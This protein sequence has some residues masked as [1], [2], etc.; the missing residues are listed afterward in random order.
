MQ[1]GTKTSDAATITDHCI[2]LKPLSDTKHHLNANTSS[3]FTYA[4]VEDDRRHKEEAQD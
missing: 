4:I 1:G 3:K 2:S